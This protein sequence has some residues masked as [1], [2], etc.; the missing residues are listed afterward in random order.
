MSQAA[1]SF[2]KKTILHEFTVLI[3]YTWDWDWDWEVKYGPFN[4]LLESLC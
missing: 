4:I 2:S 1:V 3:S